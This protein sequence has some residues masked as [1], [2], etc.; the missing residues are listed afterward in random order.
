MNG[1]GKVWRSSLFDLHVASRNGEVSRWQVGPF[2]WKAS[3][4]LGISCSLFGMWNCC[5]PTVIGLFFVVQNRC[6]R[7]CTPAQR[8]VIA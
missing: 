1:G 2:W 8:L 3:K 4:G 5:E 6:N 7:F